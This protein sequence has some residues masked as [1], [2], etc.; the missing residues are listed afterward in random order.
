MVIVVLMMMI[1]DYINAYKI[2][3]NFKSFWLEANSPKWEAN[4]KLPSQTHY[5]MY[6]QQRLIGMNIILHIVP[7]IALWIILV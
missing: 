1:V 7:N 2:I 6:I 5:G 4:T 3:L